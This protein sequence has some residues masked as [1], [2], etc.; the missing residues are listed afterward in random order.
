MYIM[1]D[2]KIQVKAINRY[3]RIDEIMKPINMK[4]DSL[5]M[6]TP[7]YGGHNN[8]SAEKIEHVLDFIDILF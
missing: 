6:Y 2:V 5:D 7:G 1:T 3:M 4:T 8:Y